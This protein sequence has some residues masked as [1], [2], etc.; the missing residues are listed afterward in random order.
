MEFKKYK[1]GQALTEEEASK[2]SADIT[3]ILVLGVH[4]QF[5]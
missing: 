4:V 5:I 1:S 2:I 3:L